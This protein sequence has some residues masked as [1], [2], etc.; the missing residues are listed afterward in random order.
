MMRF[1]LVLGLF[2]PAVGCMTLT[3]IGPF[4]D[5][6]TDKTPSKAKPPIPGMPTIPAMPMVKEVAAMPQIEEAPPPPR[7]AFLVSPDEVTETNAAEVERKLMQ[8]MEQDRI[9]A[10]KI[11]PPRAEVS[12]IKRNER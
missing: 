12:H 2:T 6:F 10:K 9:N 3:P 4:A 5:Q 7:P 11:L 1:L 8:E